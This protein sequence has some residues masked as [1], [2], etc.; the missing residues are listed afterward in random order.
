[1]S[2]TKPKS[3]EYPIPKELFEILACPLC[4]ADLEYTKGKKGLVCSKCSVKYPIKDGIPVLM[5][6]KTK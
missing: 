4:K 5:A 3:T 2:Q 6:P 1:M